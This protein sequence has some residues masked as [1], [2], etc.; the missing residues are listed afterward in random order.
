[1]VLFNGTSQFT[2]VELDG[3]QRISYPD[4]HFAQAPSSLLGALNAAGL[5]RRAPTAVT[6]W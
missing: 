4:Y 2:A 6:G 5:S 3:C 1:V